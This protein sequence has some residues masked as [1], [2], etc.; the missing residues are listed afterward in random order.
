MDMSGD[1]F[2]ASDCPSLLN[3]LS[4]E[5]STYIELSNCLHEGISAM[6]FPSICIGLDI[7]SEG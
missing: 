7:L 3:G 4:C 6:F 5:L 1:R 2:N